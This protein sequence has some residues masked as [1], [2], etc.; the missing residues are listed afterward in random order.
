MGCWMAF[1]SSYHAAIVEWSVG[2]NNFGVGGLMLY[3]LGAGGSIIEAGKTVPLLKA[4]RRW[5]EVLRLLRGRSFA[6][7]WPQGNKC[8]GCA[9]R[10]MD[11]TNYDIRREVQ[12]A[13]FIGFFLYT[14]R[15]LV[16][17]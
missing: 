11:I 10:L 5:T 2:R 7:T 12:I 14:R 16:L 17:Q 3:S 9:L 8:R 6:A 1:D 13:S 4:I 15:V